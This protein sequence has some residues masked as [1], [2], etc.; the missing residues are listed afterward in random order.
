MRKME[1]TV[2]RS[3]TGWEH[4]VEESEAGGRMCPVS[5]GVPCMPVLERHSAQNVTGADCLHDLE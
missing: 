5:Q 3:Q 4:C 1:R 2:R